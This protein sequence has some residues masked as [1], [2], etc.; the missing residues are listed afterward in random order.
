VLRGVSPFEQSPV[1]ASSGS[2]RNRLDGG[3][4]RA[5][6]IKA[7]VRL[8]AGA[9][10]FDYGRLLAPDPRQDRNPLNPIGHETLPAT[11]RQRRGAGI[12]ENDRVGDSHRFGPSPLESLASPKP[13]HGLPAAADLSK[14][15]GARALDPGT[16]P[17][18][19]APGAFRPA[20]SS[21]PAATLFYARSPQHPRRCPLRSISGSFGATGSRPPAPMRRDR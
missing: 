8:A 18:S 20:L 21:R 14:R 10:A 1:A 15:A 19:L 5:S 12:L 3:Q 16:K 7:P 9:M 6:P 17:A 4:W 13:A 11:G 2:L